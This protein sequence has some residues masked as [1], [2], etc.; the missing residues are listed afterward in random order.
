MIK[1]AGQIGVPVKVDQA[2]LQRDKLMFS[3]VLVDAKFDQPFPTMIQFVNEKGVT[4]DQQVSYDWVPHSCTNCK[5][6]GHKASA[7]KE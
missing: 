7:K 5:G 2:T 1:I 6:I 4:V 3:K